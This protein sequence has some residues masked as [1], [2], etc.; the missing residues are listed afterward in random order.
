MNRPRAITPQDIAAAV[1]DYRRGIIDA[2]DL[3]RVLAAADLS[4]TVEAL[5]I[6][7]IDATY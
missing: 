1:I 2:D 5:D 6:E 7:G 3:E 4:T